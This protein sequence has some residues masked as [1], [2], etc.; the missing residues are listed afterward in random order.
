MF[1]A[2]RSRMVSP[3]SLPV[4]TV[5]KPEPSTKASAI[6]SEQPLSVLQGLA[7]GTGSWELILPPMV[8]EFAQC[9]IPIHLLIPALNP[10]LIWE[11]TGTL[12]GR[13]TIIMAHVYIG[14]TCFARVAVE[15]TITTMH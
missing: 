3:R 14:I 11:R 1:A 15:L 6:F 12:T 10:I 7:S 5:V 2:T 13:Y 9:R 4:L 8:W